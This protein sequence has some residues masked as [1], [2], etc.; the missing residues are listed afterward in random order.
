MFANLIKV[1]ENDKLKQNNEKK[2]DNDMDEELKRF[3]S[4]I[5]K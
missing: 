3:M 1:N 4:E 2:G 5:N